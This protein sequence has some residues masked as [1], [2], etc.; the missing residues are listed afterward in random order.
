VI[1]YVID[2]QLQLQTIISKRRDIGD[3]LDHG[4]GFTPL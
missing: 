1:G 2:Q 3:C 4:G